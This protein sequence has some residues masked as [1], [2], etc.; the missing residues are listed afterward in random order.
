MNKP[1]LAI[2]DLTLHYPPRG[3]AGVDI[4]N[5]FSRLQYT[6]D[7]NLFGPSWQCEFPR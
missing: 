7:L 3:G 4:F 6:Y 1:K 2:V 5:T